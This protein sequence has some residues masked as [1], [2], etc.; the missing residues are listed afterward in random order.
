VPFHQWAPDVYEGAPTSVTAYMAITVKV[1]AFAALLRLLVEAFGDAVPRLNEL[2]WALAL[3]TIVVGNVMATI[4]GNLKRLL[5]YSS[6]AHVGFIL[7]GFVTGTAEGFSAVVFYLFAY[8]FMNLGAFAV[9]VALAQKGQ[10][11]E[12]LESFAGLA[13]TRP[14][15]AAL[16]TLFMLSLAG[17]PGTVGFIA[18]L[19]IFMAAVNA[20]V[21]WL[22]I[23]GLLMSVVSVFYY[24]RLPVL[25][26][27]REPSDDAPRREVASGEAV[28]LG[29]CALAVVFLGFFPNWSATSFQVLDWA[30]ESVTQLFSS[31]LS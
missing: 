28:V 25:M 19:T 16:M 4:Q 31:G 8:L 15:L 5:A 24:L 10:D 13:H 14:W 29:L 17:I 27:M 11:C 9:V 3:V 23:L 18:K 21:I 22:T 1:A 6:I 7:V 2:F 12:R 26:Y 20:D 30:R